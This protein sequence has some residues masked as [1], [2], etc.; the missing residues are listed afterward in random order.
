[1]CWNLKKPGGWDLYTN[2][3]DSK[4][5]RMEEI[6][7]NKS[8]PIEKGVKEVDNILEGIKYESFGKITIRHKK[9]EGKGEVREV[10]EDE[11]AKNILKKQTKKDVDAVN[12][13][14]ESCP[15]RTNKVFKIKEAIQ[16]PKK[17][18]QEAHAI[19]CPKTDKL[20]VASSEIKRAALDY[21]VSV[22]KKN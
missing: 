12:E 21:C 1:M 4:A 9:K 7:N 5:D 8:T 20:V 15:G 18:N 14:K 6:I 3:T 10:T 2:L 17:G 13:L 22:L 19:K 16:G 11:T